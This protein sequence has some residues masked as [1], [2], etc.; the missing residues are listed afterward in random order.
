MPGEGMFDETTVLPMHISS[1]NRK[2]TPENSR[3]WHKML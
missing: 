1:Q 2:E 3:H